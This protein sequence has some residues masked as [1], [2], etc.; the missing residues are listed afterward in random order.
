MILTECTAVGKFGYCFK[1]SFFFFG[2]R[3][4]FVFQDTLKFEGSFT[5]FAKE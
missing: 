1:C 5:S 2:G 3:F 4:L